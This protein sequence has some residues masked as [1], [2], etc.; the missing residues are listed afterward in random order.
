MGRRPRRR[1]PPPTPFESRGLIRSPR[2]SQCTAAGTYQPTPPSQRTA[3]HRRRNA[4][5]LQLRHDRISTLAGSSVVGVGSDVGAAWSL[6]GVR[7]DTRVPLHVP[8]RDLGRGPCPPFRTTPRSPPQRCSPRH[9][10]DPCATTR[11]SIP[12]RKPSRAGGFDSTAAAD[13]PGCSAI[14]PG[15]GGPGTREARKVATRTTGGRSG[16]ELAA[17]VRNSAKVLP[18]CATAIASLALGPQR[19]QPGRH[20]VHLLA[21]DRPRGRPPRRPRPRDRGARL[22]AHLPAEDAAGG[23]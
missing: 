11:L 20:A 22:A 4:T 18:A 9:D 16:G 17:A 8:L 21:W 19:S 5:V 14:V 12:E 3:E 1:P 2:K 7:A 15:T 23:E 6:S 13:G 10:G